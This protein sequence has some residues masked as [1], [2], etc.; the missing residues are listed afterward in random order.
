MTRDIQPLL[1]SVREAASR[2]RIGYNTML[3]LIHAGK[4]A[5]VRL[6]G[7]RSLLVDPRDLDTLIDASKVAPHLAP[8]SQ[9]PIGE[10][11]E[12]VALQIQSRNNGIVYKKGWNERL[13]K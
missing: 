4:V 13:T 11:D 6:P 3:D 1:L 9:E 8:S 5:V 12:N 10:V 7:R 2:L